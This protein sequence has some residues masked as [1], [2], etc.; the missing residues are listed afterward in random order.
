MTR[1]LRQILFI[2]MMAIAVAAADAKI[3]FAS[4]SPFAFGKWIKVITGETGIYG[5]PYT[6]LREMGFEKPENVGVLGKGGSMLDMNFTDASG[7]PLYS[8][9]LQPVAVLHK[10][11]TLY[12]FARGVDDIRWNGDQG[13][14][15]KVSKNIYSDTGA[16]FLTDAM[17]YKSIDTTSFNDNSELINTGKGY[18]YHEKDLYQNHTGTGQLFWGEDFLSEG[19]ELQFVADAPLAK[20][21]DVRLEYSFIF[22]PNKNTKVP[23]SYRM[24]LA[25]SDDLSQGESQASR[26]SKLHHI[27]PSANFHA[28]PQGRYNLSLAAT[29]TNARYLN[30]DYWLLTYPKWLDSKV[31]SIKDI[32]L[33]TIPAIEGNSY[34][35]QLPSGYTVWDVTDIENPR[36]CK[37]KV[38]EDGIEEYFVAATVGNID[39]AVIPAGIL[40]K[41]IIDWRKV[42]NRNLHGLQSTDVELVIVTVPEFRNYAEEIA[43]LHR[44]NDEIKVA[45]VT[46]EELYNEFSGGVPDPMAYRAFMKMLYDGEGKKVKNL[47]I[48][49]PSEKDFRNGSNPSIPYS[50]HIAF[51]DFEPDYSNDAAAVY[52]FYGMPDDNIDLSTLYRTKRS[53]GVGVLSCR[54][55]DDCR[56]YLRKIRKYMESSK[57][58]AWVISDLLTIGGTGDVH[59][60]DHQAE[61]VAE[62]VRELT[63]GNFAVSN[64]S[65][66]AFSSAQASDLFLSKLNEGKLFTAYIGHADSKWIGQD[67]NFFT[68]SDVRKLRNPFTCFAF[69]AGCNFSFPDK[70]VRGIGEDLLLSSDY[71][72]IGGVMSCRAVMSSSNYDVLKNFVKVWLQTEWETSPTI[73]EIYA[74]TKSNSKFSPS[75]NFFYAGDPALKLPIATKRMKIDSPEFG[76]PGMK[77]RLKGEITDKSD[78]LDGNFSGKGVLKI[79]K[80]EVTIQSYD[81][82]TQTYLAAS[83]DDR[84]TLMVTYPAERLLA[85]EF[86]IEDGKFDTDLT[87]PDDFNEYVGKEIKFHLSAYDPVLKVGAVGNF[88]LPIIMASDSVVTAGYKD[89]IPPSVGVAYN[90]GMDL[91]EIEITDETAMLLSHGAVDIKIDG[92]KF[93]TISD[94]DFHSGL[95]G[96]MY[97]GTFDVFNLSEGEHNV[98]IRCTDLAGNVAIGHFTFLKE[99]S[100]AVLTLHLSSKA[101][102]DTLG[103]EVTGADGESLELTIVDDAGNRVLRKSIAGGGFSWDCRDNRGELLP[104]GL[105][106]IK[107][108][109]KDEVGVRKYSKWETV[110]ILQ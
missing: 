95:V 4:T 31:K 93:S 81:Y 83:K 9:K 28:A 80:P 77:F 30:L 34:R 98:E 55:D 8:D 90:S 39:L 109:V 18:I 108:V 36:I 48:L 21:G 68:T 11:E 26:G 52:D 49:G 20:D 45:V 53:V 27:T 104:P 2:L 105:Y 42:E 74:E 91:L 32:E 10:D 102:V 54:T 37:S 62:F 33:F 75:I 103:I 69:L 40:P 67:M 56:R 14:F 70:G 92:E 13:Y 17:D 88:K 12:F 43:D 35:F 51:Q 57:D 16:Y 15:R 97:N 65:I 25:E 5:I 19:G 86:E 29:A 46:P 76:M 78:K 79:M 24:Q 38:L 87:L 85:M 59:T 23:Y 100:G 110:A 64:I 6:E 107:V 47:M 71:G 58:F 94:N 82:V 72:M 99:L 89:T 44:K 1:A 61:E 63:D 7:A 96:K 84:D 50:T 3:D 73:G 66:D 41:R 22:E 101:V 60:H 106:R